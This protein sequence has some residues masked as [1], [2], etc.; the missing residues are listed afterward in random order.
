[1]TQDQTVNEAIQVTK[2]IKFENR[3]ILLLRR[4]PHEHYAYYDILLPA[5][6]KY[7]SSCKIM[8]KTVYENLPSE[9]GCLKN[10]I[11]RA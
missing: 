10:C 9:E 1:M 7:G 3:K 6:L 4:E 11:F 2:E 8:Q 5:L